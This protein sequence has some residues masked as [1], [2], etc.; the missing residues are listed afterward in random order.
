MSTTL[1]LW[2]ADAAAAPG[3]LSGLRLGGG[4]RLA[5][6]GLGLL[7]QGAVETSGVVLLVRVLGLPV[8]PQPVRG[9]PVELTE[10]DP[11]DRDTLGSTEGLPGREQA[12]GRGGEGRLG[13]VEAPL[14]A[15]EPV[16]GALHGRAGRR[17][18]QRRFQSLPWARPRGL[19]LHVDR[20]CLSRGRGHGGLLHAHDLLIRALDGV[21]R[22][23]MPVGLEVAMDAL[24]TQGQ[25]GGLQVGHGVL[26]GSKVE[27]H[28]RPFW[29]GGGASWERSQA[30]RACW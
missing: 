8:D 5:G 2:A 20:L 24:R 1:F 28:T 26:D 22:H 15:R 27:A 12:R 30:S 16:L 13:A 6:L 14:A 11:L 19:A 4:E 29:R 18:S 25:G 9:C 3:G 17:L 10:D 23:A 21:A 7:H